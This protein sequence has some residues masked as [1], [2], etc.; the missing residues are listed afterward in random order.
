MLK[1]SDEQ[2]IVQ[3][4]NGDDQSLEVLVKQYLKPIFSFA[5]R[6][7]GNSAD[8][9][10][11]TQEVFVRVWKNLKKF[12]RQKSFK[13]WIFTIAKNTSIDF[14]RKK[15][16][17]PFSS[18]EN[19]AGENLFTEAL[20]DPIPLAP[21]LFEKENMAQALAAAIE[22]L[23]PKYRAVLS[24]RYNEQLTFKEIAES[25]K[26]SVNTVKSRYRRAL[27]MLKIFLSDPKIDE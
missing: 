22:K 10:D 2:L 19:N 25:L 13:T 11:L 3:Y 9:E 14:L 7:T 8:A 4:L 23:S 16:T 5:Y 24:P 27:V 21:E 15:K 18:F 1:I 12:D 26:E 20:A 17:I 6:Y